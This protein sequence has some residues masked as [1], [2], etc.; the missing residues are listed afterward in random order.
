MCN[1]DELGVCGNYIIRIAYYFIQ[2][3]KYRIFIRLAVS[4]GCLK[5]LTFSWYEADQPKAYK[6]TLTARLSGIVE[7]SL[8]QQH[9]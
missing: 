4:C 2:V 5:N 7:W 9:T 1:D 8:K 3:W 6:P